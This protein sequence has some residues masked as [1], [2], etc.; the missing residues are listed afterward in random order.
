MVVNVCCID[1][2]CLELAQN[3]VQYCCVEHLYSLNYMWHNATWKPSSLLG[4]VF[5]LMKLI[6]VLIFILWPLIGSQL[7]TLYSSVNKT[8]KNYCGFVTVR[9][10]NVLFEVRVSVFN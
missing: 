6:S 2:D 7:N 10:F 3:Q 5:L 1:V 4:I 9:G 8:F